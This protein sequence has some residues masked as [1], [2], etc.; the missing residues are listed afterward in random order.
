[1]DTI[2]PGFGW[3]DT[4]RKAETDSNVMSVKK[5]GLQSS[6]VNNSPGKA[7]HRLKL[8]PQKQTWFASAGFV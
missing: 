4:S 2:V 7:M 5:S 3:S 6:V 8:R 1:L